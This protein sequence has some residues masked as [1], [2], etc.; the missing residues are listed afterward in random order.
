MKSYNKICILFL[1]SILATT[2]VVQGNDLKKIPEIKLKTLKNK[3]YRLSKADNTVTVVNFWAS[4]CVPCVAEMIEFK[5]LH[6]EYNKK[7]VSFLA[8]TIDD[9]SAVGQVRKIVNTRKYPFTILLDLNKKVSR[10]LGV[11]SVPHTFILN[12]NQEI[13]YEHKGYKKGDEKKVK[14]IIEKEL[15]KG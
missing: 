13:I 5:K 11:S 6:E 8:I 9:P 4:W 12:S 14:E 1:F 10:S 7:G 2:L 15:N 3:T